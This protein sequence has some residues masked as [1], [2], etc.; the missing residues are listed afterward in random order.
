[1]MRHAMVLSAVLGRI[2]LVVDDQA[3]L[4]ESGSEA[5]TPRTT[6]DMAVARPL[7]NSHD[8]L[9]DGVIPSQ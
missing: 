3:E 6:T 1:M 7:Q 9:N 4:V 5:T 2:G 8:T